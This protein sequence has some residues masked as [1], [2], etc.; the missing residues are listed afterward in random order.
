M[1]RQSRIVE[2]GSTLVKV[3]EGVPDVKRQ[4]RAVRRPQIVDFSEIHP[5]RLNAVASTRSHS[6]A[7]TS[8]SI[9]QNLYLMWDAVRRHAVGECKKRLQLLL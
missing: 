4:I 8:S 1:G 6:P 7:R 9:R 2:G 5:A 3:L